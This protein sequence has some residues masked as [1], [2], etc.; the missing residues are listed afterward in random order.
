MTYLNWVNGAEDPHRKVVDGQ[1]L[2]YVLLFP[3][4]ILFMIVTDLISINETPWL[5]R[6]STCYVSAPS[7]SPIW[8]TVGSH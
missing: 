2:I 7:N 6:E 8:D 1:P 5:K 3:S 4:N